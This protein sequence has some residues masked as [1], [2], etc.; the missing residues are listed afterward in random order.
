MKSKAVG[1]T[2]FFKFAE[3]DDVLADFLDR[4]MEVL[5][6]IVDFFTII[7]FMVVRRKQ[8]LRSLTIFMDI[9]HDRTGD[10]HSVIGR[11][12]TA[13]FIE[14]HKRTRR[15]VV[16]DHRSLEHFYHEG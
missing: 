9:F 2:S 15:K 3:E 6:P 7:E 5:Y 16:E 4:N 12:T 11:R 14:K 10:R 13:D 1:N 8:S